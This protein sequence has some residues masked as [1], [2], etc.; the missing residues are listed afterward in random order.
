MPLLNPDFA[1][2]AEFLN[3][4]GDKIDPLALRVAEVVRQRDRLADLLGGLLATIEL[5]RNR[6]H[7]HPFLLDEAARVRKQVNDLLP[8]TNPV[9]EPTL[10]GAQPPVFDGSTPFTDTVY[11]VKE[12]GLEGRPEKGG[13]DG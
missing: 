2:P 5:P 6:E 12:T 3:R 11:R 13:P 1:I 9:I 7:M 10:P 4:F 8:I